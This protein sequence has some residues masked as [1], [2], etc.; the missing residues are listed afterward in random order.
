MKKWIFIS[1]AVMILL[2]AGVS[3]YVISEAVGSGRMVD[4]ALIQKGLD[5]TPLEKVTLAEQYYGTEPLIILFGKDEKDQDMVVWMKENGQIVFYAWQKY[6]VTREEIAEKVSKEYEMDHKIH[7][8]PGIENDFYLWEALY[9][10]KDGE[11]QYFYFDFFTGELLR[12]IKL[13]KPYH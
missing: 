5:N 2:F 9:K 3:V 8:T 10:T 12:S 6:G 7:I 4:P 11:F 1:I 13:K